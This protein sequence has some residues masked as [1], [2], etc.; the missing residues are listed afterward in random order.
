MRTS[1]P[2]PTTENEAPDFNHKHDVISALFP[3]ACET[4]RPILTS[5]HQRALSIVIAADGHNA[6]RSIRKLLVRLLIACRDAAFSLET[7]FVLRK[8]A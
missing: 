6:S 5:D 8:D 2:Q 1:S 3:F 4:G 7:H